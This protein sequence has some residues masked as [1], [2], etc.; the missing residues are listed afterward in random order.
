[1]KFQFLYGAIKRGGV[2]QDEEPQHHFNSF[3]VRLK[4]LMSLMRLWYSKQFQFLYGA[5]K[6]CNEQDHDIHIGISIPL[7]CD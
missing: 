6:S 1:M 5:I 2:V 3:M 7:W 4:G